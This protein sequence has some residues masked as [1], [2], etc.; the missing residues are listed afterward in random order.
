MKATPPCPACSTRLPVVASLARAA[1]P[2]ALSDPAAL[3]GNR[4]EG[5]FI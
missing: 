4:F 5:V 1:S 2:T 3:D